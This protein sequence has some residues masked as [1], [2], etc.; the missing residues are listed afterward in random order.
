MRSHRDGL[1][2]TAL[3]AAFASFL[4][5]AFG[6]CV[7]PS[8]EVTSASGTGGSAGSPSTTLSAGGSGGSPSTTSST[9][10]SGGTTSSG[11]AGSGGDCGDTTSDSMNCG[12]C[13]WDCLGGE[14]LAGKCQAVVVVQG[15]VGADNFNHLAIDSDTIYWTNSG[16][17]FSVAKDAPKLSTAK[18]LTDPVGADFLAV[19]ATNLYWSNFVA[20]SIQRGLKTNPSNIVE[21]LSGMQS[22]PVALTLGPSLLY[23]ANHNDGGT[24]RSASLV[25]NPVVTS[26]VLNQD[27]VFSLVTVGA[28][29]YWG[30]RGDQTDLTNQ[31]GGVK[32]LVSGAAMPEDI[33]K[34]EYAPSGLAVDDTYAYWVRYDGAVR[35]A[36]TAG[37][38]PDLPLPTKVA[39]AE[40]PGKLLYYSEIAV[41]AESVYWGGLKTVWRQNKDG[42]GLR[43]DFG[44]GSWQIIPA[45]KMEGRV[46]YWT[47]GPDAQ[48]MRKVKRAPL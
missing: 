36:P 16:K 34:E 37:G 7:L 38:S 12:Q 20:G 22:N 28:D 9:G 43:Q 32:K 41:D 39:P 13:R 18:P 46:V 40:G 6:A 45:L 29:L 10:G 48:L 26:V 44:G 2:A 4:A 14:C 42:S 31:H 33:A 5:G 8:Y 35:R 30:Y 19:D 11:T 17:I 25:E 3:T 1:Y 27:F 15:A 23:W 24:I 47:T 21:V